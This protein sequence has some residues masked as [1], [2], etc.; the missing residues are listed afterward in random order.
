MF[1][2]SSFSTLLLLHNRRTKIL[3]EL[4]SPQKDGP[5]DP[6]DGPLDHKEE[7][8]YINLR[9]EEKR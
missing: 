5:R 9:E 4:I 7:A 6:K 8:S 3:Y 1:S 2:N